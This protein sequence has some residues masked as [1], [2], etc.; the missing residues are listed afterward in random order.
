MVDLTS[1]EWLAQANEE[2]KTKDCPACGSKLASI[3]WEYVPTGGLL[4]GSQL[5]ASVLRTLIARCSSCS[6]KI[7]A[8]E[9]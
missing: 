6:A 9:E 4:S 7:R 2:I 1:P 8:R 3:G 5:K